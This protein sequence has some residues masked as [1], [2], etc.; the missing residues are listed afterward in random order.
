MATLLDG[1]DS[2]RAS[3]QALPTQDRDRYV[4]WVER[5]KSEKARRRRAL[6]VVD[7]ATQGQGWAGPVRRMLSN[8]YG[9]PKGTSPQDAWAAEQRGDFPF[10]GC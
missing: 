9:V 6:A 1:Y 7:R 5:G 2:R 4:S 3:W 8:H 10:G